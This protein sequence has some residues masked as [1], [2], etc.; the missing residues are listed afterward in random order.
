[1]KRLMD[2]ALS[3]SALILLSPVL[4]AIAVLIKLCSPGPVFYRGVRLGQYGKPFRILKF[5]S[6]VVGAERLGGSATANDDRRLTPL[7][8]I[9]RRFKLDEL[10][11]F[12]N[13]FVGEMSLVGPRPEV[14]KYVDVLNDDERRI[15]RLRPGIT[16]WASIW[17]CD[18]GSVLAG[19]AD[20]E[21]TYEQVIRPTKVKLQL[22]YFE[23]H[24][25]LTDLRIL[26]YTAARLCGSPVVPPELRSIPAPAPPCQRSSML[27]VADK[28]IAL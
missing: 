4:A 13:V 3:L 12:W 23:N 5:R 14:Q 27:V 11:Q 25:L 20:P 6:M 22:L 28:E 16:D 2:A 21:A 8:A 17:N 19:S 10:P 7:G 15:L 24:S 9:L 26:G 1:M 18:E